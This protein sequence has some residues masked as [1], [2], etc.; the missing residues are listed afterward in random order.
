MSSSEVNAE[1][2]PVGR[3]LLD[4]WV[5]ERATALLDSTGTRLDIHKNGHRGILTV[6]ITSKVVSTVKAAYITPK[7]S[8]VR[9]RGLRTELLEKDLIK[10]ISEQDH[11]YKTDQAI[12]FW[13]E[14][15]QKIQGMTPVRTRDTPF[16]KNASFSTPI[17]ESLD[18]LTPFTPENYPKI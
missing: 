1:N 10:R 13:S 7:G 17:N 8:G 14:N 11:D 9:K 18:D 5:E 2:K 6:D 16:K 4:N 15:Y 3:C 12:T